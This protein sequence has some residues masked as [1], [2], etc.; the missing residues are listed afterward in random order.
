[1]ALKSVFNAYADECGE[2]LRSLRFSYNGKTLFLSS[3]GQKSVSDLGMQDSEVIL[4]YSNSTPKVE[5]PSPQLKK[6]KKKDKPTTKKVHQAKSK[7]KAS[8][9][10]I[11]IPKTEKEL[12]EA[13]SLLLS[14]VFEE[15][16]PQLKLIRQKLNELLLDC[17]GPKDRRGSSK[18]NITTEKTTI[19]NPNNC[20]L[21]GKAG[22]T[23]FAI[24]VGQ[25]E[26]LHISFKRNS[27]HSRASISTRSSVIDLHGCNR[28]EAIERLDSSLISWMDDA[29]RGEYPWVIPATI[30]CGAGNQILSET[31][32]G[33]IKGNNNVANAPR[34]SLLYQ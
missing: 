26:N 27:I 30:I 31:V 21:G 2:S 11:L 14:K 7:P 3:L 23:S 10:P 5:E 34:G 8:P 12:Q 15:A 29:M 4:I 22:R 20:G 18:K 28:D 9:Q 13:H 6:S 32:E 25:I 16:E 17:Q 33:W 19:F 1:M 24:N